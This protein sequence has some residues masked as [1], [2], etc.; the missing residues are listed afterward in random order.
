MVPKMASEYCSLP[1]RTNFLFES[2]NY[3]SSNSV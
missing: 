3:F 1:V 2:L